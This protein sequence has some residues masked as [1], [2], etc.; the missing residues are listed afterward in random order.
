MPQ[1]AL[2]AAHADCWCAAAEV[3]LRWQGV[4]STLIDDHLMIRGSSYQQ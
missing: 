4:I 3:V 1:E 2:G